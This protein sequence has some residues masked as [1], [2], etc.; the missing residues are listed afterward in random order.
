MLRLGITESQYA[1]FR[2]VM[3]SRYEPRV[4]LK[5]SVR[6]YSEARERKSHPRSSLQPVSISFHNGTKATCHAC[7][8]LSPI[9][10]Q[11]P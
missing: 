7:Y 9:D 6:L 10:Y 2:V 5:L 11:D 4:A 1:S 8:G 3:R